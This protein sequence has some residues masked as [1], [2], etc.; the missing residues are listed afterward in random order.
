MLWLR[1]PPTARARDL[2]CRCFA[3][4]ENRS[5]S[6]PFDISRGRGTLKNQARGRYK[7]QGSSPVICRYP[8]RS[9]CRLPAVV[10]QRATAFPL[11]GV[12]GCVCEPGAA[13]DAAG[14]QPGVDVGAAELPT[15]R[16]GPPSRLETW[17]PAAYAKILP[18]RR[19]SDARIGRHFGGG[20][21]AVARRDLAFETLCGAMRHGTAL[22]HGVRGCLVPVARGRSR[23]RWRSVICHTRSHF[24]PDAENTLECSQLNKYHH[25]SNSASS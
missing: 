13:H 19:Q 22:L 12:C 5:R 14:V 16:S 15:V 17:R 20:Q 7:K 4:L 10:P 25:C 3:R 1:V 21:N 11:C 23:S 6:C 8:D 18:Q 24:A 9:F 2:R